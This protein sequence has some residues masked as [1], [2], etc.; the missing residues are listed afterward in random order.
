MYTMME[1]M[2]AYDGVDPSLLPAL[3]LLLEE[4]SVTRA[5]RR[6]GVSQ[7]AM[8]QKL[9]QLREALGDPLL[10]RAKGGMI[11]T[12]RATAMR[13]P[14]RAALR[15]LQAAVRVG[16]VFDPARSDRLFTIAVADYGEFLVIPHLVELLSREAPDVRVRTAR[17]TPALLSQLERGEVDLA[18][19]A[20]LPAAPGLRRS[21][22][23][24]EGFVVLARR[25]H[26]R[27]G[28]ELTF[29]DYLREGH[30][31]IAPTGRPGGPVD[32]A[33]AARGLE[34]RVAIQIG[35]FTPAPFVV[36]RSDLLLTAPL[37]LAESAARIL[38]VDVF[39]VPL[40][41]PAVEI[42]MVWHERSH[43]DPAHQWLREIT[44][45]IG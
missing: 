31:L 37:R 16:A 40:P 7:P 12:E 9:K 6:A 34:R 24:S 2:N 17:Q 23:D 22:I 28:A 44:R 43:A 19:G 39:E 38:D 41:V 30:I 1:I 13:E 32:R 42:A 5:A 4:R 27:I 15:S 18:T 14:L 35:H 26:P 3:D 21:K 11:A 36:A 45:R 8:S 20:L 10:V 25:G 33:L 29:D